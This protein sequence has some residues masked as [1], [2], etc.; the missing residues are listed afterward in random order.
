MADLLDSP[1]DAP[2]EMG[3]TTAAGVSA[4]VSTPPRR[5]GGALSPLRNRNYALLFSGQAISLLGDQAYG[6]AL[7]WTV[8]VVTG[9][10][11]QMA[12][13]L[14]AATVPR[15]L[16]LLIGGA[17]ADRLTPRVIMIVADMLRMLVVGV[18][19]VTLFFGLPPLWIV[20]L[21]A[22][23]EGAGSG[24]FAPGSQ[25]L[26]PATLSNDDLPAGNGLMQSLQ[27][28]TLTVGPLLGGIA[29]AAEASIAFLVDAASF[30]IS[31]LAL[32]GM[33]VKRRAAGAA[34]EADASARAEASERKGML[35]EIG[36]GFRYAMKT[37]L[38][39]VAMV[40]TI[41]GNLGFAGTLNV[42]LIVLAHNLSPSA[43]TLGVILAAVGVGGIIGGLGSSALG[44]LRHRGKIALALFGGSALLLAAVPLVAGPASKLPFTFALEDSQRVLA[45]AIVMGLIGFILALAD[46]MIIT[47]MQQSIA[48][49]Y[50][51]RVFSIQFLAGGISQPLSLLGAGALTV[52]FGP[53]VVFLVGAVAEVIAISIGF[54][55][56]ELR[57]L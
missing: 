7:P 26:L 15:V 12:V 10:P 28:L 44:R 3:T 38:V 13:V 1:L 50:L 49:E 33:R 24:L 34:Q 37:P 11:N 53:G 19:G 4:P 31:A 6:L 18:L 42:G 56:R 45:V 21:L 9:D 2:A 46:T 14:T 5:R 22:G 36:A 17:L 16:L 30:G 48:P 47:V 57:N 23:L 29:T 51:G 40:V 8:L 39:R 25:A 32:F 41:F 27:F 20:A 55:S 52:A 35:R 54:A 43:V